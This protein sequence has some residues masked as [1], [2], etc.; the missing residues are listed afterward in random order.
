MELTVVSAM[1]LASARHLFLVPLG[2]C[3][4]FFNPFASEFLLAGIM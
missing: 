3:S 4:L 1:R 2:A